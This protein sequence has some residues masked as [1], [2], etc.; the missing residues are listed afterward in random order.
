MCFKSFK[1]NFLKVLISSTLHQVKDLVITPFH[2]T[3]W[4]VRL[5]IN[6]CCD[7]LIQVVRYVHLSNLV[8]AQKQ[9]DVAKINYD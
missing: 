6:V 2:F 4:V 7:L 9:E 8:K 1:L 5:L 3:N